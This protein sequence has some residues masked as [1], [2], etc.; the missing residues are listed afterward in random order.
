MISIILSKHLALT[1]FI[2]SKTRHRT[3]HIHIYSVMILT[4][5]LTV[6]LKFVF[7]IMHLSLYK[8]FF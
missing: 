3:L 4:S 5:I 1:I 6:S 7:S 8:C 2:T